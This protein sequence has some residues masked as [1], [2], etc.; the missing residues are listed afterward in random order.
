MKEEK[1]LSSLFR[2]VYLQ[3][4]RGSA[5][6]FLLKK[7]EGKRRIFS[8]QAGLPLLNGQHVS[9]D[10]IEKGR[11]LHVNQVYVHNF[12]KRKRSS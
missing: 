7:E 4:S 10:G 8:L 12:S 6:L 9:I 11:Y 3:N 5:Y 1:N 2:G